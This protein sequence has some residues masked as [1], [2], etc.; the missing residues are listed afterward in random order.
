MLKEEYKLRTRYC[1]AMAFRAN[2]RTTFPDEAE[3]ALFGLL[4]GAICIVGGLLDPLAL[5]GLL[6]L[7]K[8][9]QDEAPV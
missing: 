5:R 6:C 3:V 1:V 8:E 9:R 2:P 7:V 4:L